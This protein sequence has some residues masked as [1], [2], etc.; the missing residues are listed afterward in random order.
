MLRG[1]LLFLYYDP[2]ILYLNIPLLATLYTLPI[3]D[4][5]TS[6][7]LVTLLPLLTLLTLLTLLIDSRYSP[8]PPPH[9]HTHT[10]IHIAYYAWGYTKVHT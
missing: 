6:H 3:I 8:P 1:A 5:V 10:H 9:T 4:Y 2:F 7:H